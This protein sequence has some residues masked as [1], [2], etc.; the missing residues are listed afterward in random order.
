MRLIKMA[1][2][3]GNQMFIY[4]MYLSMH[5]RFGES[6]RIDISD[7]L[8][9]HP[10]N[11][12]ELHDVFCLPP[13][14]FRANRLLKKVLEGTLFRII[15][16]RHQ[17]GSMKAYREPIYWPWIYYK[18]FYQNER[19]FADVEQEVRQAF[20]FIEKK[21]NHQSRLLMERLQADPYAVSIHVRRGDYVSPQYW[22]NMG[23]YTS[24]IYFLNALERMR[25]LVPQAHFYVFSD[26]LLWVRQNLPL[27]DAT[28]VDWNMGKDSWQDMMLMSACHHHIISNSTF[29]W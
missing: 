8:H 5:K 28:F 14:E 6:V 10:H 9:L 3:L 2:G 26:D 7:I 23:Q 19:Y 22:Q 12:Y 17:H 18:G 13:C 20:T 25:A 15:L 29:S 27:S 4:A 24:K 11:G 21:A 1:G 16:E